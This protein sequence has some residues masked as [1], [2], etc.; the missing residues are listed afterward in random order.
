[1]R[2]ANKRWKT[3]IKSYKFYVEAKIQLW[4]QRI[5]LW[6][7][8]MFFYPMLV[9]PFILYYLKR[10]GL[11]R[12]SIFIKFKKKTR[13]AAIS[14]RI[15]TL[16]WS[17]VYGSYLYEFSWASVVNSNFFY[18]FIALLYRF[19]SLIPL[20]LNHSISILYRWD[21]YLN[22]F[23]TCLNLIWLCCEFE[24]KTHQ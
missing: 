17:I 19:V 4:A 24:P 3:E 23:I 16:G 22:R 6:V 7:K 11:G 18:M 10:S 21:D 8:I 20:M 1:L 15:K 14:W 2:R 12:H 9:S 5:Q 13:I